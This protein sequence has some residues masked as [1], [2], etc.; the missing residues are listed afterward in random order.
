MIAMWPRKDLSWW[1]FVLSV[2][3]LVGAYPFSLLANLTTPLLKNWWAE[4]S[5][6][7]IDKRIEKLEKQLADY[8]KHPKLSEGVDYVLRA[9]EGLSLLLG[10]CVTMLS[11]V[12]LVLIAYVPL[13]ATVQDKRPIVVFALVGATS[14]FLIGI[15][16]FGRFSRFRHERSPFDRNVLRK[17]VKQLKEKKEK[18][19]QRTSPNMH[20]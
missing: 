10:L 7:S 19:A 13:T 16:A 3:A 14:A 20:P 18:L 8:E 12:L 11:V 6:A 9:T 15:V 1:A 17:Y 5:V 4:R 2:L